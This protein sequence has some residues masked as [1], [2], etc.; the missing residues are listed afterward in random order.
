[1]NFWATWCVPCRGEIPEFNEMQRDLEARG[2]SIVGAS[3]S[4]E[5]SANA[6][7][8]FQNDLKQNYTVIRGA[9]EIGNKFGNGPGLPVTYI[10]DREGRIRQK[11]VGSRTRDEFEAV[12]KPLL[13]EG[14]TTA[15]KGN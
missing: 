12:I 1:M 13:E 4:P 14:A 8:S 3:V 7:R 11:F 6:I 5:D 9:E 15:Q 2:L 10:L